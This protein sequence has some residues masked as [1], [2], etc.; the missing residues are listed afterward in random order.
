MTFVP[1][2]KAQE[3]LYKYKNSTQQNKIHSVWQPIKISVYIKK[4]ENMAHDG[5]KN[6]SIETYPE[7]SQMTEIRRHRH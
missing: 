6:Q 4:Q 7:I 2:N 3:Y 1:Q 5:K